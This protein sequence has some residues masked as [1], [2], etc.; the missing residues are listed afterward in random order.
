MCVWAK[1]TIIE[2]SKHA[3]KTNINAVQRDPFFRLLLLAPLEISHPHSGAQLP[4]ASSLIRSLLARCLTG[5]EENS[6]MQPLAG[7][8]AA[9]YYTYW[10]ETHF[11]ST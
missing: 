8:R 4:N 10:I 3:A 1:F 5:L 6:V 9:P 7:A 2:T 11:M